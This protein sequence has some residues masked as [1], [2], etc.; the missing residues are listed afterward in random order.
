VFEEEELAKS[1]IFYLPG[2]DEYFVVDDKD[3]DSLID[4]VKFTTAFADKVA[5]TYSRL[6]MEKNSDVILREAKE[7][8]TKALEDFEGLDKNPADAIE[9][10]ILIKKNK[11]WGSQGG[12][13][14]IRPYKRKNGSVKGHIRKNSDKAI[15][16]QVA[17]MLNPPPG[18]EGMD[19]KLSATLIASKQIEKDW[20]LIWNYSGSRK[21]SKETDTAQTRAGDFEAK[22]EA[23]WLRF[24][25][26]A[27]VDSSFNWKEKKLELSAQGSISYI[28]GQGKI[29]G[30]WYLPNKD[31]ADLFFWFRLNEKGIKAVKDKR[32]CRVRVKTVA[33]GHAFAGASA[34]GAIALPNIDLGTKKKSMDTEVGGSA[35][36]GVSAGGSLTPSFEWSPDKTDF[37]TLAEVSAGAEGSFGIGGEVK[38]KIGYD[39]KNFTMAASAMLVF[40]PG[41]KGTVELSFGIDE[42]FELLAH[43]FYSVDY[44]F[45]KDVM[46]EAFE[47]FVA[48]AF[49]LFLPEHLRKT[50]KGIG[51]TKLASVVLGYVQKNLA[52]AK[53]TIRANINNPANLKKSPPETLGGEVLRTL[54]Q[55]VEPDD[56]NA[57]IK[58]LESAKNDHELKWIIRCIVDSK[59]ED[60]GGKLLQ[61]GIR[62][63][64]KYGKD[65]RDITIQNQNSYVARIKRILQIKGIDYHV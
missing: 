22:A 14:Y 65:H 59:A 20:P 9:E 31:G 27:S 44:H 8:E 3:C 38:A 4:E 63:L 39:G 16:K 47:A 13:V 29:S 15:K 1:L 2:S 64:L 42:G 7:L 11:K 48:I 6:S 53:W 33:E 17:E 58:V 24:V 56:F 19:K 5:D 21:T 23:Q 37:G 10:M 52:E 36:A 57:I 61:E 34:S 54:M 28:L 26:G 55:S 40:G 12:A 49:A 46:L 32:E 35:F 30:T 18:K 51:A 45:V 60:V 41:G 43:I 25:A 62:R 50:L